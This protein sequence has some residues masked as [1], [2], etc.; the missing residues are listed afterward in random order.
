MAAI[1]EN[2]SITKSP[3][4]EV[5]RHV[6]RLRRNIETVLEGKSEAIDLVITALLARGHVLIEDVPGVGKTTLAGALARSI[7]GSFRRIQFTSDLLP[8]D[9]T[10]TSVFHRDRGEFEFKPGPIFANVVLA[11]EI[12]RTTPKTQSSLLEAM[13]EGQVSVDGITHAL[14]KPFMVVAT[15]NPHEFYGT[16]PLPESQLDRFMVRIRIGYPEGGIEKDII[17]SGL[18]GNDRIDTIEPVVTPT[19][20]LEL[21]RAVKD[22]RFDDALLDYVME[23]VAATRESG[24]LELGISTRGAMM[25]HRA[26]RAYALVQGRDFCLPDDVKHLA[27]PVVAHRV[28]PVGQRD[29]GVQ[30]R[31]ASERALRDI[32]MTI[33]VPV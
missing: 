1:L 33:S 21:Q 18:T 3:L 25:L 26:A 27:I 31:S 16:Y 17:R 9:I 20:V 10:G 8:A 24:L 2:G 14:D 15:Q 32:L 30:D 12:N 6:T 19:E 4:T 7:E 22:V 5:Q 23:L 29:G 28:V 11:D 13:N